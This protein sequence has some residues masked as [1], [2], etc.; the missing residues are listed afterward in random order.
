MQAQFP[1]GFI[2]L[3]RGDIVGICDFNKQ[4]HSLSYQA[5][6]DC[7]IIPYGSPAVLIRTKFF[8]EH[9]DNRTRFAVTMNRFV[10]K[11]LEKYA[12]TW[13][14]CKQLYDFLSSSHNFW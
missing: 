4:A 7:M 11:T 6:T 10:R 14:S 3:E 8:E 2:T 12:V 1:G 9:I 13:R 5:V